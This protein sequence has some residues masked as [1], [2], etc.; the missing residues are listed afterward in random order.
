MLPKD[1]K[2]VIFDL[3]S[4]WSAKLFLQVLFIFM[5]FLD[6]YKFLRRSRSIRLEEKDTVLE[7]R[8]VQYSIDAT[9]F[10]TGEPFVKNH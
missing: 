6:E 3:F 10:L 2:L 7:Q 4:V 1:V 9:A 8:A 5:T